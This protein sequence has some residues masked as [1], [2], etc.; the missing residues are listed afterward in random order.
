MKKIKVLLAVMFALGVS[1]LVSQ[2]VYAYEGYDDMPLDNWS[3]NVSYGSGVTGTYEILSNSVQASG[4]NR[5]II[6][7]TAPFPETQG[8]VVLFGGINVNNHTVPVGNIDTAFITSNN[9]TSLATLASTQMVMLDTKD[10]AY[11]S[12]PK[13]SGY[14]TFY[15]WV[16][17]GGDTIAGSMFVQQVMNNSY[18]YNSAYAPSTQQQLEDF[19]IAYADYVTAGAINDLIN[20]RVNKAYSEGY[21]EGYEEGANFWFDVG[22]QE[23]WSSQNDYWPALWGAVTAPFALFEIELF[24]GVTAGMLALIP[25]VFGLIAFLFSLGGKKK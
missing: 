14:F 7:M 21:N 25:I 4:Y 15:F 24:P 17:S 3:K 23:G 8:T 10:W 18:V 22:Y 2:G 5:Y 11:P 13:D 16:R 6:R 9:S 20:D 19:Y 12:S 1:L